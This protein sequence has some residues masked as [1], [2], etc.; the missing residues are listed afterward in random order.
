MFKR[1]TFAGAAIVVS[2]AVL[3]GCGSSAG[4][5]AATAA[6][7]ACVKPEADTQVL[8]HDGSTVAIEI[9][10][11]AARALSGMEEETD[12]LLAGD[13]D[14]SLDGMGVGLAMLMAQDCLVEET[15][16]PGSSDQLE[17]GDEWDGWRY[18]TEEGAGS[19]FTATFIATS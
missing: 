7:D 4:E 5:E 16:Y 19:E 13:E 8:V 17:D 1:A 14:T 11:D 18:E 9:K 15:G 10:G 12:A 6:Y 3:S 2:A